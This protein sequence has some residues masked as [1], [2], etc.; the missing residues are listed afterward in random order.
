MMERIEIT[1]EWVDANF[2]RSLF[3]QGIKK[4]F[5]DSG[6]WNIGIPLHLSYAHGYFYLGITIPREDHND[7]E[8][9]CSI[10]YV[11][12]LESFIKLF[13]DCDDY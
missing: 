10:K 4:V 11:D 7:E 1:E 8:E 13:K 12:Q 6:Q 9:I 2:K 3:I 5:D